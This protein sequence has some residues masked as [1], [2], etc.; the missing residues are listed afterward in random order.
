MAPEDLQL[1]P[2]HFPIVEMEL[3]RCQFRGSE[4]LLSDSTRP[5]PLRFRQDVIEFVREHPPQRPSKY[6][7]MVPLFGNQ[8]GRQIRPERIAV[9]FGIGNH[10]PVAHPLFPEP[11]R[12]PPPK[13]HLETSRR[14]RPRCGPVSCATRTEAPHPSG[15]PIGDS[16]YGT[17]TREHA[18]SALALAPG[19]TVGGE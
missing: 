5:V 12:E 2:P 4:R 9:D 7:R 14:A 13:A 16:R 15:Q 17:F 19:G 8:G 3:I 18:H 6:R 1:E 10:L 11:P